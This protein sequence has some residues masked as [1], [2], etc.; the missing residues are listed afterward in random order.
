MQNGIALIDG[1]GINLEKFLRCL[2]TLLIVGKVQIRFLKLNQ[3]YGLGA[4]KLTNKT[5][6]YFYGVIK[7]I[8]V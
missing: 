6:L 8:G 1:L 3:L 2:L 4:E 5:F 7:E